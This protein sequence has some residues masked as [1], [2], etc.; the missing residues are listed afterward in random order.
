MAI[1][2]EIRKHQFYKDDKP[3]VI[4]CLGDNVAEWV[5]GTVDSTWYN[6]T[7]DVGSLDTFKLAYTSD[8]VTS[9]GSQKGASFN[10]ELTGSAASMLEQWLFETPCSY[11][12][13]FDARIKDTDCGIEYRYYELKPDNI[14]FCGDEGCG[15]SVPLRETNNRYDALKRLS[16][17]DNWQKWFSEDGNKDH[18]TFQVAALDITGGAGSAINLGNLLFGEAF[19]VTKILQL[20]GTLFPGIKDWVNT[21]LSFRDKMKEV[22]GFGKFAPAPKIHTILENAAIQ[23]GIT[24]DTPFDPG[25]ELHN[26]C[27]FIPYG[28]NYWTNKI[29]GNGPSPSTKHIYGNR[30][31]WQITEFLDELSKLYALTWDLYENTLVIKF[32]KDVYAQDALMSI[33]STED[34]NT[35]LSVCYEYSL[36]KKPGY[37]RYQYTTDGGDFASN[38]VQ[39]PYNDIV[40]YDGA[41]ENPMLEGSVDKRLAFASTAF[42]NDGFGSDGNGVR[43][44]INGAQ[45]YSSI[46]LLII[47]ANVASLAIGVLSL[48]ASIALAA[49]FALWLTFIQTEAGRL[50]SLYSDNPALYGIVRL[51]GSG[52]VNTPR[53]LR[54]DTAT[55]IND[56]RVVKTA[57]SLIQI[58]PTFNVDNIGYRQQFDKYE[59]S[60]YQSIETVYNYPLYFDSLYY[61]NL[62]DKYHNEVDNPMLVNEGHKLV[63]VV[64]PL[65]CDFIISAGLQFGGVTVVGNIAF[66]AP[67]IYIR[68]TEVS[69]DY[70]NMSMTIK[71]KILNK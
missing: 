66:I 69:V 36:T 3:V 39:L 51:K 46:L 15:Y 18:P 14:E 13:Y 34:C 12:N 26:D 41:T 25:K 65:T 44:A 71:G 37:G 63:T 58:N 22:L 17:H 9:K 7:D 62:Y 1:T 32:K 50:R 20:L 16:I 5:D 70:G 24:L 57:T 48:G 27:L 64:L 68:V 28:G 29:P 47:V 35:P 2:I 45:I 61:G 8:D 31:I 10:I 40:D 11:I 54:W 42:L 33:D 56:A 55:P 19:P 4:N 43:R 6:I 59:A 60:I 67:D 52:V 23:L 53:V 38:Q 21:A 30:Y 49:I